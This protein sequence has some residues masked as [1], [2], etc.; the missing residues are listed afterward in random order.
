M[1]TPPHPF[2][3]IRAKLISGGIEIVNISHLAGL[4]MTSHI[5]IVVKRFTVVVTTHEIVRK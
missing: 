2:L 5:V 4:T 3:L 1:L